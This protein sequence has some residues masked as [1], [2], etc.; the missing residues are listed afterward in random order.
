[1]WRA[2]KNISSGSIHTFD[3]FG[4]IQWQT[5][6][7]IPDTFVV[8]NK[9]MSDV[10]SS[11]YWGLGNLIVEKDSSEVIYKDYIAQFDT[12]GT[13]MATFIIEGSDRFISDGV[14]SGSKLYFIGGINYKDSVRESDLW[15]GR[16]GKS[17]GIEW[18][19]TIDHDSI[20]FESGSRILKT[21]DGFVIGGQFEHSDSSTIYL[22]ELNKS[23]EILWEQEYQFDDHYSTSLH[24]LVRA[25]DI[26]YLLMGLTLDNI[27]DISTGYLIRVG[28]QGNLRW[29]K[30]IENVDTHPISNRTAF[31]DGIYQ[32]EDSTFII[33][34]SVAH[35]SDIHADQQNLTNTGRDVYLLSVT[36]S[37]KRNWQY[38]IKQEGNQSLNTLLFVQPADSNKLIA[39]GTNQGKGYLLKINYDDETDTGM[40]EITTDTKTFNLEKNYPNLFNPSTNIK[41]SLSQSEQVTIN[42]YNTIGQK[43]ETL[44][45]RQMTA[46][47]HSVTFDA[48]GL[49]SGVYIYRLKAGNYSESR[50]MLLLK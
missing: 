5:V 33:G 32:A 42:V 13:R 22:T 49:P 9:V 15:F 27:S 2:I 25:G 36:D 40:K 50:K 3:Q 43:I 47:S 30:V 29:K 45:N 11:R 1:M 18:E 7:H 37:G 31:D 19:K 41:F 16:V 46:G 23:G 20:P 35:Y 8:V 44:V 10:N 26:G 38:T 12:S 14:I 17:D 6:I 34:G 39:G 4:N 24:A 21:S 28:S 48:E